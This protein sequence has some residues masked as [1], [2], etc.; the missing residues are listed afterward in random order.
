MMEEKTLLQVKNWRLTVRH[1]FSTK[2][3]FLFVEN[4]KTGFCDFPVLLDDKVVY[5]KPE[6]IP[7]YFLIK[8]NSHFSSHF[9]FYRMINKVAGAQ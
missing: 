8:I 2:K 7:Q 4:T 9:A 6:R 5:D 1:D 3:S